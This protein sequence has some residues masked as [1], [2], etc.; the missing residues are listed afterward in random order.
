MDRNQHVKEYLAYYTAFLQPP[1][2][3]VL[4]N[5]PWGIGKTFLL[6]EF[7]KG[8]ET[9]KKRAV[10]VS[11]YGLSSFEE[12]DDALF[13][14][15]YPILDNKGIQLAG[16]AVKAAGKFFHVDI[17]LNAKDILSKANADLFVFDDLERCEIS[18]GRVLGYI[19]EFVEHEDRKVIIVANEAEIKQDE[20]YRRIREKVIGKTFEIQSAFEQALDAF[21]EGIKSK[22]ARKFLKG[23]IEEITTLYTQANLDNLRI[24]QQTMWDLERIYGSLH[25]KHRE[26]D[27]AMTALLRL[28]FALS[29]ELKAGRL[30]AVDLSN[31]HSAI[32]KSFVRSQDKESALE[33]L[34]VAQERY[35]GAELANTMLSDETFVDLL[36]RGIVNGTKICAELDLSSYFVSADDEPA[37]R[38]VWYAFERTEE[39]FNAALGEMERAFEARQFEKTGEILHVLGL[40]LWLSSIHAILKTREQ[41]IDEGK[42]YIDDLYAEGRIEPSE[43]N[44]PFS[45]LN[46]SGYAG[47]GIHESETAD[48]RELHKH[49]D[50]R[51]DKSELDTHPVIAGK[52][53]KDMQDDPDKFSRHVNLVSGQLNYYNIPVLA[54]LDPKEFVN[55]LLALHPAAQRTVFLALQGRYRHG[56]LDRS[57]SAERP[58]ANEV[59]RTLL[60]RSETMS[61]VSKYRICQTVKRCLDPVLGQETG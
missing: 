36:V 21:V 29:F 51:R 16:R 19:N 9:A 20:E 35:P 53:L 23:K 11:L 56:N 31:R 24:L 6:K 61:P 60:E 37:W 12:V 41:V 38:T 13:R 43:P 10:Y 8:I 32:L 58:W 30:T 22:S 44:N 50:E 25:A 59:R 42:R 47:L 17:D 3:A 39:Q 26:N 7:L 1:H 18:V 48:Y 14:A 49:L 28:F 4:L 52:I 34:A 57:L 2:F 54:T 15:I 45:D 33:L 46:F 27:D 55:S 5:G 40:R